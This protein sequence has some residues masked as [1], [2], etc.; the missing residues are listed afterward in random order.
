[1]P[2]LTRH[3]DPHIPQECWRVYLGDIDVGRTSQC[4]GNP[5]AEAKWQWRCGFYP[6][7]RPGE[8]TNGTAETS[9]PWG[10]RFRGCAAHL[11]P[12]L[13]IMD[14]KQGLRDGNPDRRCRSMS[15]P[16]IRTI[17]RRMAWQ[18]CSRLSTIV[19]ATGQPHAMAIQRYDGAG[20]SW[21][22]IGSPRELP[23]F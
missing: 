1:M 2:T 13:H 22:D 4:V 18:I 19:A 23:G 20:L 17:R 5:G 15:S 14:R 10:L 8:C 3:R 12:G 6:G 16:I 21:S 7:S 11:G 9:R